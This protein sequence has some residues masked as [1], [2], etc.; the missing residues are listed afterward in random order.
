MAY[1]FLFYIFYLSALETSSN[2]NSSL[3]PIVFIISFE[4]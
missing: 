1:D 2:F 3:L 4:I